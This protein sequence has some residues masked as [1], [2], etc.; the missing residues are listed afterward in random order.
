M[1]A[2]DQSSAMRARRPLSTTVLSVVGLVLS[3]LFCFHMLL[4]IP[5]GTLRHT[6]KNLML[7][8]ISEAS[9]T[10]E[11]QRKAQWTVSL[12]ISTTNISEFLLSTALVYGGLNVVLWGI[13]AYAATVR[14]RTRVRPA[15][16]H[17]SASGECSH[18][19]EPHNS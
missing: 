14:A 3:L 6:D 8:E 1:N 19:C 9:D 10:V 18:P 17:S 11:M 2:D 5:S 16:S 7:R 15:D 12:L 13:F 4:S